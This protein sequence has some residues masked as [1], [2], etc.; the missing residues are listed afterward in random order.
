VRDLEAESA[1]D[2]ERLGDRAHRNSDVVHAK[3]AQACTIRP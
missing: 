1:V 3:R 2:V